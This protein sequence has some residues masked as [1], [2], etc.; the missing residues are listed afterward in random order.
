MIKKFQKLKFNKRDKMEN[1]YNIDCEIIIRQDGILNDELR[2]SEGKFV[3][4]NEQLFVEVINGDKPFEEFY[5]TQSRWSAIVEFQKND[6]YESFELNITPQSGMDSFEVIQDKEFLSMRS[7]FDKMQLKKE[8]IQEL[9]TN[10]IK[11][12]I[13]KI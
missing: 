8:L 5:D 6:I 9:N 7:F 3:N 11:P 10:K 13:K 4:I 12:L 2:T 1:I